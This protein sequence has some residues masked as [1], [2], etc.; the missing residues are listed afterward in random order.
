MFLPFLL[1]GEDGPSGLVTW[2]YMDK[3][4]NSWMHFWA[5]IINTTNLLEP[6]GKPLHIIHQYSP[7]QILSVP[8]EKEDWRRFLSNSCILWRMREYGQAVLSQLALVPADSK[9]CSIYCY[10]CSL[11]LIHHPNRNCMNLGTFPCWV[12]TWG[13][14][15]HFSVRLLP[16]FPTCCWVLLKEWLS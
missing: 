16:G 13:V 7:E 15:Y 14:I 9:A 12:Y 5:V 4:I 6:S 3:I 11:C 2:V 1:Q 8:W 10:R